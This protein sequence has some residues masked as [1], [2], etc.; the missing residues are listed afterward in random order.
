MADKP[1]HL[2]SPHLSVPRPPD[3]TARIALAIVAVVVLAS[4]AAGVAL[5]RL[6]RDRVRT[7]DDAQVAAPSRTNPAGIVVIARFKQE[8]A[9]AIRVGQAALVRLA[10]AQDKPVPGRVVAI[11]GETDPPA[12]AQGTFVQIAQRR[13][14]RIS[15][16]AASAERTRFVQGM[17]ARVQV[18]TGSGP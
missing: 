9:A 17:A 12:S 2:P 3:R 5:W 16:D 4:A 15:V 14:V 18:D 6:Q 11:G 1:N 10:Q 13:P 8:D 7:T